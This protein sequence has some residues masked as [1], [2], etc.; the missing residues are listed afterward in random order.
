MKYI[1]LFSL[2]LLLFSCGPK[3]E[4]NSKY[5]KQINEL[6]SLYNKLDS[7]Y[8]NFLKIDS[9]SLKKIGMEANEKYKL[10]KTIYKSDTVNSKFEEIML[11]ARGGLFKTVKKYFIDNDAINQEFEKCKKQYNTLKQNLIHEKLNEEDAIN[12]N[13]EEKNALIILNGEVS[14]QLNTANRTFSIAEKIF[15]KMDSIIEV[16]GEK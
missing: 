1:L 2:V 6:S 4:E 9:D 11:T 10:I 14:N 3:T 7:N 12:Y 8:S 13:N 5:S 15:F 16:H